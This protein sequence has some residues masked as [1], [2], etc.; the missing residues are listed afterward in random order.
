MRSIST[1]PIALIALLLSAC[2][3]GA[4][5]RI[6]KRADRL[7]DSIREKLGPDRLIQRWGQRLDHAAHIAPRAL[8]ADDPR[9]LAPSVERAV[10]AT[11]DELATGP[12]QM[13]GSTMAILD[14][15]VQR[16]DDLRDPPETWSILG[17]GRS[18][19][20]VRHVAEDWPRLLLLDKR[21]LPHPDDHRYR[22]DPGD[23]RPEA[24]WLERILERLGI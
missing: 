13:A 16:I 15:T 11:A 14:D 10:V 2:Q 24:G 19:R 7:A 20:R 8:I 18:V 21:V 12:S 23:N 1:V 9:Q 6:D 22:T 5:G 4:F 17:P 3:S